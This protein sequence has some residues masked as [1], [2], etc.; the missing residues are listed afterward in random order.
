MVLHVTTGK[1][2]W[3]VGAR[4]TRLG[5]EVSRLV[6]GQYVGKQIGIRSVSDGHEQPTHLQ[7]F[8]GTADRI[9]Y[10]NCAEFGFTD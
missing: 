7:C 5:D 1:Y 6:A 10:F 3:D 4:G 2:A 9:G 8:N